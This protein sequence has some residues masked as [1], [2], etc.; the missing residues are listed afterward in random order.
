MN[1]CIVIPSYKVQ[2][3]ILKVLSAVGRDVSLIIVVDDACPEGSGKIV[4]SQCRDP[5]VKV[6]FHHENQGV[7]GAVCT[8]YQAALEEKMDIIVKLDSDGQ[9][10]PCFIGTLIK[11]IVEGRADYTKGNRFFKLSSLRSMPFI[12]LFGN[13]VLSFV[14][15]LTSGYWNVMDP[16]NGFTAVYSTVLKQIDLT[17]LDRRYFFESDMLFR[18][19]TI[20]AVVADV[21][22]D[23]LY[24]D[25]ESHLSVIRVLFEFPLKYFSR[26]LKRFFYSYVLRDFNLGSI[27]FF[28]GM[29]LCLFG[30]VFG[31]WRYYLSVHTGVPA[32]SGQVMIAGLPVILGFQSLWAALQF[33]VTNLPKQPLQ[34]ME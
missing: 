23:A 16:T 5:R 2:K 29:T 6:L 28:L 14:A 24:G 8:G 1:V 11:P 32:T 9:M 22:M 10:D 17:K 26:S 12:R 33:D 7:G 20:R 19:G 34:R 25:E 21:P 27:Q 15:K 13:S 4:Q 3:T 30:G 18:L 31:V